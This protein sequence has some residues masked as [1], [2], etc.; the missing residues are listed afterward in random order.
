MLIA[1]LRESNPSLVNMQSVCDKLEAFIAEA[2]VTSDVSGKLEKL[3][4]EVKLMRE[5]QI[6]T[7]KEL[8]A[9]ESTLKQQMDQLF[10]SDEEH[11]QMVKHVH[12]VLDQLEEYLRRHT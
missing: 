11:K 5:N 10:L 7:S 12:T 3:T 2:E 8:G 6:S 4:S 9:V 1:S